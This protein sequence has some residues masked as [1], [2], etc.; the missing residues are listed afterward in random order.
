MPSLPLNK[1]PNGKVQG[2]AYL[3]ESST[4]F[5][6]LVDALYFPFKLSSKGSLQHGQSC[7]LEWFP[8]LLRAAICKY[9]EFVVK[10]EISKYFIFSQKEPLVKH[11]RKSQSKF[12]KNFHFRENRQK[13]NC[14]P[15]LSPVQNI[16]NYTI[17]KVLEKKGGPRKQVHLWQ[18][19]KAF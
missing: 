12:P 16:L 11:F 15:T 13:V 3:Y 17:F 1:L 5:F 14:C 8:F 19:S 10:T 9:R 2:E 6:F 7:L 18:V 4:G